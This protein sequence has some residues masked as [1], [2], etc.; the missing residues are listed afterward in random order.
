MRSL[1]KC[2][3]A[4]L[5]IMQKSISI[6][7]DYRYAMMNFLPKV[8]K[9]ENRRVIFLIYSSYL[10]YFLHFFQLSSH[11]TWELVETG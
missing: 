7:K 1:K 10:L 9:A 2:Y 3:I 6:V 4:L 11:A 8:L 5:S